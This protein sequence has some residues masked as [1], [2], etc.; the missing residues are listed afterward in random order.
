MP[1]EPYRRTQLNLG[2]PGNA[3]QGKE[4]ASTVLL[5]ASSRSL[6]THCSRCF[7]RIA[8]H[9]DGHPGPPHVGSH[10]WTSR[11]ATSLEARP[12][13][14]SLTVDSPPTSG[15]RWRALAGRW[16]SWPQELYK[17]CKVPEEFGTALAMRVAY[18]SKESRFGHCTC[19]CVLRPQKAPSA[20]GE[21]LIRFRSSVCPKKTS[22]MDV[23]V[24]GGRSIADHVMEAYE[25]CCQPQE[26][27]EGRKPQGC[28]EAQN[29]GSQGDESC[30]EK[31]RPR[32]QAAKGKTGHQRYTRR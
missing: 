7:S 5:A 18:Y 30:Y 26:R 21:S 17:E 23:K 12:A 2:S 11:S 32:G 20:Q 1:G 25:S 16:R 29:E 9:V 15:R 14:A 22:R 19:G 10:I 6:A 28:D 8:S 13:S 31:P 24:A 3:T 27:N 4:D